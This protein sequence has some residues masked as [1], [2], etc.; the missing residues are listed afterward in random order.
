M[1]EPDRAG[2]DARRQR[3]YDQGYWQSEDLWT[4]IANVARER[5]AAIA[6][7]HDDRSISFAALAAAAERLGASLQRH[8]IARGELVVIHAR[9]GIES[10]IALA[11]CAWLGA[12]AVPLPPIFTESQVRAVVESS[13]A[14]AVFCLSKPAEIDRAARAAFTCNSISLVVVPDEHP[15][16]LEVTRW[17]T[18]LE[19]APGGS[20]QPVS[21][22]ALAMLIY[23]SGT[24]GAP[25]GVMH[26]A[27]TLRYA[28]H[29]RAAMHGVGADDICTLVC[30]F[31]FVGG[32]VFG[33]L[34]A[35]LVGPTTIIV[36]NWNAGDTLRLIERERVTYGLFMPTHTHD[37]LS[38]PE[39]DEIDVSS[40]RHAAMGGITEEKREE[41]RD[42]L[43]PL[44]F[45]GYGM[46]ECLGHASCDAAAPLDKL[47]RT[48]GRPYPGTEMIVQDAAGKTLPPGTPGS[49]LVRG[50]SRCLGY[51][52]SPELTAAAFTEDGFFRT[53]DICMLDEQSYVTFV[54]REKDIIRRGAVTIIPAEVENALMRHPRI[55]EAAVVG[56]FDSRLGERPCACLITSDGA[57]LDLDTITAFLDAEGVARYMWPESVALFDEFPRTP[58][59]KV[60]KPA[61][62]QQ[63]SREAVGQ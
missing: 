58:S 1:A 42:R 26:S 21:A 29:Q 37:L 45:P 56:L 60:M 46:S 14:R 10:A 8:G 3:Y 5:G 9:N 40:L 62:V 24:T 18:L 2:E 48:E 32:V 30:Q 54:G 23:S 38:A 47:M 39:L 57:P 25:K 44:P 22:D 36:S 27:N 61:L 53:G 16:D 34:T 11:G 35:M 50:P 4:S 28:A 6:F 41:V 51:F 43:C 59:L 15:S 12:V 55:R 63:M 52:R 7:K 20:R 19:G 13:G 49:V 33:M 31:G 17:S